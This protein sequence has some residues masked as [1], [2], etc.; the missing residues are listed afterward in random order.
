VKSN[1]EGKVC[2]KTGGGNN[3]RKLL[4][5]TRQKLG[6]VKTK[7]E[8]ATGLKKKTCQALVGECWGGIGKKS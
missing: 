2:G 8:E 6:K 1:R 5:A 7:G 4:E 3:G